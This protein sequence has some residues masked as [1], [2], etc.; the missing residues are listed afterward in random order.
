MPLSPSPAPFP[1]AGAPVFRATVHGLPFADRSRHLSSLEPRQALLLI[2]DLPGDVEQVWVHVPGGDPLGHLP[3]E[4]ASWLAPWMRS[5]GLARARVIKV[6]DDTVP[7]W[8]RL[9]VEVTCAC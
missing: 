9:L 2:P 3:G 4:I 1:S 7:S 5:G 8:K 6:G